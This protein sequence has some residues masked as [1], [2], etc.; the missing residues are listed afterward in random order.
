MAYVERAR[1]NG[2]NITIALI[3]LAGYLPFAPVRMYDFRAFYCAGKAVAAHADPYR[4]HPLGECERTSSAPG[5]PADSVEVT[6]PAPLPG[7][8]LAPFA[9]LS[10]IPFGP[11]ALLWIVASLAALGATIELLRRTI[12]LPTNTIAVAVALPASVVALPLGQLAPFVGCAIAA[13]AYALTREKLNYAAAAAVATGL[14]PSI[15]LPLCA[16][17][18]IAVPATRPVIVA[19]TLLL[20]GISLAALGTDTN[21]EYLRAVLHAHAVGNIAERSQFSTTH[22][23]WVA[24]ARGESAVLLGELWFGVAAAIGAWTALR[25]RRSGSVAAL[26]LVPPA[27]AVFGGLYVHFSQLT[28]AIPAFLLTLAE[29]PRSWRLRSAIFILAIPWLALAAFPPFAIALIALALLYARSL[30]DRAAALRLGF[31]SAA[32]LIA[33]FCLALALLPHRGA[34]FRVPSTGNPL[35]QTTWS[36]YVAWRDERPNPLFLSLQ[37]PTVAA[38][39]LCLTLLFRHGLGRA[40]APPLAVAA[41]AGQTG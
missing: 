18:L 24:G 38:F 12:A 15:A 37:L 4:E 11:C 21:S 9:L 36:R 30:E 31:A 16:T 10:A 17:L 39:T 32:L 34:A 40:E 27:F 7:Y 22:F 23:A 3:L 26:A 19:G 28:L 8:A 25:I 41:R 1:A 13:C 29:R 5:I 20:A 35:V 14:D 33:A 6:V 2:L